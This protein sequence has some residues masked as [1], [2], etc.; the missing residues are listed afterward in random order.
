M[1]EADLQKAVQDLQELNA[2]MDAIAE[3]TKKHRKSDRVWNW[4][5]GIAVGIFL[6]AV[7]IWITVRL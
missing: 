3:Q 4:I 5:H 6:I 2:R 1:N 7:I